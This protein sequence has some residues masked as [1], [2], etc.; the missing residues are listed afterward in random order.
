MKGRCNTLA[1]A[2]ACVLAL[3]LA[4]SGAARD[5]RVAGS[6][7]LGAGFAQALEDYARQNEQVV[8][9]EFPG[10]RPALTR[11][12]KGE[13]DIALVMLPPGEL[14]PGDPFVSRVIGY[15]PVA[16]LVPETLPLRQITLPQLRA[17][18]GAG[19]VETISQWGE[20]GVGG[21][22]RLRT[23]SLHGLAPEAGLTLPLFRRLLL[24]DGPLKSSLRTANSPADLQQ[25]VGGAEWGLVLG[26]AVP[27]PG[28]P[29]RAL[30][31][32]TNSSSAA[33]APTAEN[34]HQGNYSLRV[35]LHL[36]VRRDA[37]PELLAFLRFLLS[38]E[39]GEA[40]AAAHFL[41]LPVSARNQ[42]VFELEELR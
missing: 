38:D 30:A 23:I 27:P 7:L 6:D 42:L 17:V 4:S 33:F 8:A 22:A 9:R 3:G 24:N 29:V 13:A 15:Q 39:C 16:V 34:L 31:V 25:V 35:P 14:P 21:E 19:G 5:V 26:P 11:L 36:V 32:A 37:V 20:L 12:E 2:L 28:G 40:L 1:R 18:F 41:P 10:S